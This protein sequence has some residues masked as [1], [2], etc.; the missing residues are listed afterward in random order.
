MAAADRPTANATT[1]KKLRAQLEHGKETPKILINDESANEISIFRHTFTQFL[2]FV[3]MTII[4]SG[5][6]GC[7]VNS[8]SAKRPILGR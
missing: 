4:N 2:I 5:K 7:F 6:Y 1:F 3:L 8:S